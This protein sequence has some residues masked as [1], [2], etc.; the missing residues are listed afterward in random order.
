MRRQKLSPK[1]IMNYIPES[2]D[3]IVGNDRLVRYFR[4]VLEGPPEEMGNLL[5]VGDPGTGKTSGV[6]A[7]LR[8]ALQDP[9]LGYEDDSGLFRWSQGKPYGF[10]RIDGA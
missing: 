7:F 10:V 1:E 9:R 3:E 5:V 4:M 8:L 6:I 2:L